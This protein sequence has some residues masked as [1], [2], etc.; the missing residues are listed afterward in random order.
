[1]VNMVGSFH[2]EEGAGASAAVL[3]DINGKF[4]AVRS[5]YYPFAADAVSVE[6]LAMRDGL[7]LTNS[8]G[9][10]VVEAD[11][12]YLEVVNLCTGQTQWCDIAGAIYAECIDLATEIGKVIFMHCNREANSVAHELARFS[13]I[14]KD[15]R[16]WNG[17]PPSFLLGKPVDDVNIIMS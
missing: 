17:D 10:H 7:S 4:Y 8:M 15:S 6:A 3:R 16:T 1:M 5:I 13:Y 12:D 9:F 2:V 14:N 11:S